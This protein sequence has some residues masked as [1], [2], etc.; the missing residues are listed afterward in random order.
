MGVGG[1]VGSGMLCISI[2]ACHTNL[3]LLSYLLRLIVSLLLQQH[4]DVDVIL[5]L[6]ISLPLSSLFAIMFVLLFLLDVLFQPV[7]LL[8]VNVFLLLHELCLHSVKLAYQFLPVTLVIVELLNHSLQTLL[9]LLLL[10]VEQLAVFGG[11]GLRAVVTVVIGIHYCLQRFVYDA[12]VALV[13]IYLRVQ[14]WSHMF[15]SGNVLEL[16]GSVSP[17]LWGD[18]MEN[19]LSRDLRAA[20]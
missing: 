12:R 9:P 18:G 3:F 7:F 4:V 14:R 16:Y 1:W 15:G 10:L 13:C 6:G 8:L 19:L 17:S 5:L 2:D 11:L 20:C